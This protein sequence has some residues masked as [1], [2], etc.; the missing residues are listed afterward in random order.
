MTY[1]APKQGTFAVI[2]LMSFCLTLLAFVQTTQYTK[3]NHKKNVASFI[4]KQLGQASVNS[5]TI[6]DR[7]GLSV[8]AGRYL[9]DDSIAF[10]GFY[11]AQNAAII[12][13]GNPQ[14]TSAVEWNVH[15]NALL[16]G[17]IKVQSTPTNTAQIITDNWLFLVASIFL[18][19]I[20]WLLYGYLASPNNKELIEKIT[21][22][23]REKLV[24]QKVLTDTNHTQPNNTQQQY[25][26]PAQ[27]TPPKYTAQN[28]GDLLKSMQKQSPFSNATPQN[29]DAFGECVA[30]IAFDDKDNFL[31]VLSE[32]RL[33]PYLVLCDEL[34]QKTAQ[35][36]LA[37]PNLGQIRVVG[38]EPFG[39][40]GASIRFS[41]KNGD[42][43]S[44]LA[45]AIFA[46]LM[47]MVNKVIYE[48]HRDIQKF[49][50]PMR[51]IATT[52]DRAM[53][54]KALLKRYPQP[55]MIL[56]NQ[57][58]AKLVASVMNLIPDPNPTSIHEKECRFLVDVS[59][60][61]ANQLNRALQQILVD[62]S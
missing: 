48:K 6:D 29:S 58:S 21:K 43:R 61:I 36:L 24:I 60:T 5:L 56:M 50:L 18:H 31:D 52:A 16:V 19:S 54:G 49:A 51:V 57:E 37:L 2:I 12:E 11:D 41:G 47:P 46:K 35:R 23:V 45:G 25:D 15:N 4:A 53:Y 26:T 22:D 14:Q 39:R 32:D 40:T 9:I 10:I 34:L 44:V 30:Y 20:I 8:L 62:D 7:V 3:N 59:D 27:S 33:A 17:T 55:S 42:D 1:A 13:V 38:I 28:V